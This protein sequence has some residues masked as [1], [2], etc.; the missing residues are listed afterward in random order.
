MK[1]F[2]LIFICLF[3]VGVFANDTCTIVNGASVVADDGKYLG[4]ISNEYDSESIFN[5]YGTYGSEYSADSVW[6]E[7][8]S[9]GGEYSSN[10]PFNTF[11][12][13][14]P[15]LVKQGKAIAYLTVSKSLEPS[16]NPFYLKTCS[17]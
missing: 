17:F 6:N 10:S 5:D 3:S 14:P 16:V 2:L 7:Y 1:P 15:K 11:T 9:Y 12:S 8:G 13:T 4:K